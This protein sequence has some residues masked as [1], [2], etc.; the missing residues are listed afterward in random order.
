MPR[1]PG[2]PK[3]VALLRALESGPKTAAELQ[4]ITGMSH[5]QVIQNMANLKRATE[6]VQY[7]YFIRG[8]RVSIGVTP[9]AGGRP[10]GKVS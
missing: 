4:R 3:Q 8:A 1:W 7:G 5:R 9:G 2:E 10:S 6:V